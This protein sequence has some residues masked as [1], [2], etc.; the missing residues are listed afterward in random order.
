MERLKPFLYGVLI[1]SVAPA[2]AVV[3]SNGSL[4]SAFT[5]G[6]AFALCGCLAFAGRAARVLQWLDTR[7]KM[8]KRGGAEVAHKPHKLEIAGAN[9]APAKYIPNHQSE[10]GVVGAGIG[11]PPI[12]ETPN[13]PN[14][15]RTAHKRTPEATKNGTTKKL[16]SK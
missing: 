10:T 4:R 9:P 15:R 13:S 14:A 1:G 3:L 6:V 8:Q 5:S 2:A 11:L 7:G 12:P 16:P